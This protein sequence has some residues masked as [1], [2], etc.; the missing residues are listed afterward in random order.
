MPASYRVWHAKRVVPRVLQTPGQPRGPR[1]H[2]RYENCVAKKVRAH[3]CLVIVGVL[4]GAV[5]GWVVSTDS[6]RLFY[7]D[8]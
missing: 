7:V 1:N 3:L 2:R 4:A 6:S 5:S 8:L